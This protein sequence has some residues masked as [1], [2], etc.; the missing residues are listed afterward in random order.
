MK[1]TSVRCVHRSDVEVS[2]E[3]VSSLT[4][5]ILPVD[6]RVLNLLVVCMLCACLLAFVCFVQNV[7]LAC[8]WSTVRWRY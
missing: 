7:T 5:V 3:A 6:N 2:A 8:L 1:M 4:K